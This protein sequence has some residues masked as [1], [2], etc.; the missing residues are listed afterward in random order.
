MLSNI[1]SFVLCLLDN[2]IYFS[3]WR[4]SRF[5][6][7]EERFIIYILRRENIFWE[8]CLWLNYVCWIYYAYV[9]AYV[10]VKSLEICS[11]MPTGVFPHRLS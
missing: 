3:V 8:R 6:N 2:F 10:D 4:A 11:Y 5:Q 1:Q 7:D 9:D